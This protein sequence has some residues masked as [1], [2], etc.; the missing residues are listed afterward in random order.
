MFHI[1][2]WSLKNTIAVLIL[3]VLVLAGGIYS[4]VNIQKATLPNMSFP[5]LAIQITTPGQSAEDVE[6]EITKPIEESIMSLPGVEKVTSSTSSNSISVFVQYPFKTDIEQASNKLTEAVNRLQLP[7]GTETKVL[8][9]SQSLSSI[10]QVAITSEHTDELQKSLEETI[11]PEIKKINGVSDA[12]LTGKKNKKWIIEIN[13][14]TAQKLGITLNKVKETIESNSHAVTVGSVNEDGTTIPVSLD[15]DIKKIEEL[16]GILLDS[17]S[18]EVG[19]PSSPNVKLSDISTIKSISQQK[20]IARYNGTPGFLIEVNKEDAANTVEVTK[21]VDEIIQKYKK[22]LNYSIY[23]IYNEG[24]EVETSISKMIKEGLYGAIFTV[25]VIALFLRDFRATI[26]SIISLPV[27]IFATITILHQAGYTLNIMTLGGLAVA[28]GRIVDDSIVVIENMYRWMQENTNLKISKKEIALQ[29][30]KQVM[31]AV[32]S[33]T[34]VTIVV[35]LPMVFVGGIIGEFFRPFSLAVAASI[36]I[37]L[38]V[39][40]MLIPVLGAIFFKKVKHKE[41]VGKG[42]LI[43]EKILRFALK[44]RKSVT[45][46]AF[47]LLLVS[48]SLVPSLGL[49]FL[50]AGSSSSLYITMELPPTTKLEKTDNAAKKIEQYLKEKKEIDYAN[51]SIGMRDELTGEV[52][53]NQA[54]FE[55]H[56]KKNSVAKS[57]SSEW[58]KE[59]RKILEKDEPKAIVKVDEEPT[60][61]TTGNTVEVNLYSEDLIALQKSTEEVQNLL[62]KNENLKGVKSNIEA[63]KPKWIISLNEKGKKLG[64]NAAQLI[65]ITNEQLQ[66]IDVNNIKLNNEKSHFLIEYDRKITNKDQLLNIDIPTAEGM[67]K[68]KE[69]A[70]INQANT[71]IVIQHEKGK[72]T[73]KVEA[74]VK[75]NNIIEATEKITKDVEALSLSKGVTTQIGGGTEDISKGIQQLGLAI[76]SAVG[77]VF[78]ILSITFGGLLTPIIILSSLIFV[79]IG[80]LTALLLSGQTLS[81]S[82]MIGLLMLIGIVVTNAVVLLDRVETN[83]KEGMELTVAIIE[84]AKIRLRPIL[85]TAIATI[86]ALIP[87]AISSEVSAS[88]ALISKGL[89]I[90]VIGGLTTSTLLTLIIIPVFYMSLDKWRKNK[91][92]SEE[93]GY[94]KRKTASLENEFYES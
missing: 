85:M 74:Q 60:K 62:K 79:P 25:I 36:F 7:K 47:I 40:I 39:S 61:I 21:K 52:Q 45:A 64:L 57:L 12:A 83:R 91:L 14:D 77:L 66:P 15:G 9:I 10:Y 90:T 43:F 41:T 87:M 38:L 76:G 88:T 6:R 53:E 44:R 50:P 16:N 55:V 3:C 34:L 63:V 32:S 84:A 4:T 65:V 30:T 49:S 20:E 2:K 26:L 8:N 59:I 17:N 58:K 89:A 46:C 78:L 80:S 22:Q 5:S 81:M 70:N 33:S 56:L 93:M 13:K 31:R 11:I 37:S 28:I 75:D 82:A 19:Q 72:V 42:V 68:L 1:T 94:V 27:S 18:G 54:D 86:C 92:V 67:I 29:A 71:P 23:P 48:V 35:F 73:A 69:V 51:V 24:E